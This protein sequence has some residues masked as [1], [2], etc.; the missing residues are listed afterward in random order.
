LLTCRLDEVKNIILLEL[1]NV[2]SSNGIFS[3]SS[4]QLR[5]ML[6]G[7]KFLEEIQVLLL[8][9][10]SSLSITFDYLKSDICKLKK[11]ILLIFDDIE[12]IGDTDTTKKIFAIA[13][14][15]SGDNIHVLYQYSAEHLDFKR[16]EIEKYIPHVIHLTKIPFETMVKELW[17]EINKDGNCN[18]TA[19]EICS[20]RIE[21]LLIYGTEIFAEGRTEL[22]NLELENVTVRNVCNFLNDI[23]LFSKGKKFETEQTNILIRTLIVRNFMY[24]TYEKLRWNKTIEQ[25]L[26]FK[27]KDKEITLTQLLIEFVEKKDMEFI[28]EVFANSDNVKNY[29]A[30][31]ILNFKF[32]QKRE[33]I[34][35]GIERRRKKIKDAKRDIIANRSAS[36]LREEN[37]N[38]QINR[39]IW[40]VLGNGNSEYSNMDAFIRRLKKE[41]LSNSVIDKIESWQRLNEDAFNS[42]ICK[43]NTTLMRFGIDKFLPIFQALRVIGA[44]DDEWISWLEF[45]FDMNSEKGITVEMIECLNYCDTSR[46]KVYKYAIE[47]FNQCRII[48]NM[49]N[50]KSF[51]N[52]LSYYISA[53]FRHGYS[54]SYEFES[55]HYEYKMYFEKASDAPHIIKCLSDAKKSIQKERDTTVFDWFDNEL[56]IVLSFIIKCEE[57]ILAEKEIKP[58]TVDLKTNISSRRGNQDEMERLKRVFIKDNN[59]FESELKRSFDNNLISPRNVREIQKWKL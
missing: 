46:K 48:G 53:I 1:D 9:A 25:A 7:I 20:I 23:V 47:R 6:G 52:F 37:H 59:L 54:D 11:K 16:D 50:E 10:D 33:E 4:L 29:M 13:E 31:A 8:D 57:I 55:W 43:N 27:Y 32:Y 51:S 42:R 38:E 58:Y 49:N 19:D 40:N 35:K 39:I 34:E 30:F 26:Y 12:R 44:T 56:D 3:R 41:V 5:K 45:Y 24:E 17:E 22:S 28:D 14:K 21:N 18:I 15:L 36:V 2:L